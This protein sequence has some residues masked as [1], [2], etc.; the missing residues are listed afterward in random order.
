M[1]I[2]NFKRSIATMLNKLIAPS[3]TLLLLFLVVLVKGQD[4]VQRGP[5]DRCFKGL[6]HLYDHFHKDVPSPEVGNFPE[7]TSWQKLSCCTADLANELSRVGSHHGLYNY[8]YD[9]CNGLSPE[10]AK[11]AKVFSNNSDLKYL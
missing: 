11:Y 7:C 4:Q 6:Y 3:L 10:C 8:S 5:P 1:H 2:R 9:L